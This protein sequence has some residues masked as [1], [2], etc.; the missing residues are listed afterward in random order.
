MDENP[1]PQ[2][3]SETPHAPEQV[4]VED[5]SPQ[6]TPVAEPIT[7]EPPAPEGPAEEAPINEPAPV[8]PQSETER[9][10]SRAERRINQLTGQ[11][12]ELTATQ[13]VTAPIPGLSPQA[14]KLSELVQD[15]ESLTPEQLDQLGQKVYESAA[16]TA[17]G[18]NSLEVQQLRHE[19]TQQRAVDEVEKQA[20]ILPTQFEELNPDSPKYNP[21]LEQKIEAA[22]KQRAV[23]QNP[24]NPSIKMVDP[25]VRLADVAQDYIEVARAAAQAGQ[26]QTTATLATQSDNSAVTPTS[27]TPVQK[28]FEDMSLPEQE[29]WLRAHGRDV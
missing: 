19:L 8:A 5:N 23:I 14:P 26:A 11:L 22:Y 7:S 20:A 1:E 9:Q 2:A 27:D 25:S 4:A 6:P 13:Q 16:Q 12:K 17:K 10:P 18:L 3:V 28:S 29:T 15:Q 24:Y 21:V